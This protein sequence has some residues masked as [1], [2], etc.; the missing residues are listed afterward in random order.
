[1]AASSPSHAAVIDEPAEPALT[2]RAY[3]NAG[4]PAADR[5]AAIVEATVIL[6][7]AGLDIRW[8]ECAALVEAGADPCLRPLAPNEL[9]I[10]FVRLPPPPGHRG[11]LT[12]G[13]S[14]VDAHVRSGSLATIYVDR[15]GELARRSDSR[16]DLLLGRAVA[17]EIGHLLLGADV[18]APQGLMR[19]IWSREILCRDRQ[20]DWRF[21]TPQARTIRAAVRSRAVQQLAVVWGD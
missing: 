14:L 2:I 20:S 12:L 18:H 10:R 9:S 7:A 15:V 4:V 19:A 11:A 3:D 1:M 8:V 17:H 21:T 5:I 6:K 16:A 13:Y